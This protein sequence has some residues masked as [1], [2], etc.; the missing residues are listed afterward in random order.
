MTV[1]GLASAVAG[2][3]KVRY[4]LDRAVIDNVVFRCH[5]RVTSAILF[6]CC[7]LCTANSLIGEPI[8][9][10]NDG[11]V[12]CHVINTYCWITSTF[13]LPHQQ[14]KPVGTHVAHPGLGNYVDEDNET[15]YHSYYQWVP[16]MLFFQGVLF[17]VPHW[18]WKNWEEGKV[19]LISDGM[20][21]ALAT[22]NEDRRA[23]Q[24]R[25][26]QYIIDTL[27]LHNFYASG[28]FFCEALN[29][30]NV[31]GNIVFID[32][33]LG[34]A[35]MTYGTEVLS[36]SGRNQENRTDPMVV[37]FPRVTKCTFH[38]YGASGTIQKHDALCVLAL[39]IINEKIYIFLWFW[40]IILA[41][42]SG[43]AL[44]YSLVIVVLPSVR[45]TILKRRF[46]FGSPNGVTA[47][48]EKMQIGDFLLLYLLGQ[49]MNTIVFAEVL[50]ELSQKLNDYIH[51]NMPTAPST[52]ELYP[53]YPPKEKFPKETEA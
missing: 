36:F 28:Y 25:L 22:T 20:R 4:L 39:N 18:I 19:R 24:S 21:G 32:V 38:K 37:V 46:R 49:N 48:V 27:H 33:F 5:Y 8:N 31:I 53:M 50:D 52:L 12:A 44:L 9:C 16:F 45:E 41:V 11:A 2:F 35:F 15:H 26:V 3:V 42:L 23:R 47:I 13:T 43:L 14:G 6:L 30:V 51:N 34:G 7:I 17:Y 10:I 29:F 40:L 1:L